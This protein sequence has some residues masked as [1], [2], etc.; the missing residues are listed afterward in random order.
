[1]AT[2]PICG[3]DGRFRVRILGVDQPVAGISD[4]SRRARATIQKAVDFEAP[5]NS[6]GLPIGR[7]CAGPVEIVYEVT[8][9][10]FTDPAVGVAYSSDLFDVGSTVQADYI[11]RKTGVIGIKGVICVVESMTIGQRVENMAPFSA[12]LVQASAD[13]VPLVA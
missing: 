7:P 4:W 12:T 9:Y 11:L 5:T 1:M 13:P 8:G 2:G 6:Q 10:F 3:K